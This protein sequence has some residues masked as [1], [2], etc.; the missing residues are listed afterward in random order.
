[1]EKGIEDMHERCAHCSAKRK[2][3]KPTLPTPEL[4]TRREAA[5]YLGISE[6]T[7]AIW[8]CSARYD[9]PV[10]KVGRLVKYRRSE[11]DAFLSRHTWNS[12]ME[13]DGDGR[14]K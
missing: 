4:L 3:I 11:L 9:L 14:A 7:L 2:S 1:M 12:G 6:Q 13:M 10:I 8:K 5:A